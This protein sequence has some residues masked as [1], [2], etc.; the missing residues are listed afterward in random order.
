MYVVVDIGSNTVRMVVFRADG[1]NIKQMLNERVFCGLAGQ[2]EE[3]VLSEDGM[4]ILLDTLR[5]FRISSDRIE[6]TAEFAFA[7]EGIRSINNSDE[8]IRRIKEETGFDV[9]VISGE[10]EA[11]YDYLG[12][13][14][15]L[16][17]K[18][19]ILS[20]VGGG[21]TEVAVYSKE[22]ILYAETMR[23][24]SLGMYKKFVKGIVATPEELELIEQAT[25]DALKDVD[26]IKSFP[27]DSSFC[28]IGGT[29]RAALKVANKLLAKPRG[30][31]KL[32]LEE[33]ESVIDM[34]KNDTVGFCRNVL[35]IKP[36]RLH[37]LL[38]GMCIQHALMK[39]I[40]I[41]EFSVSMSGVREG[42]LK[43]KL[44]ELEGSGQ[45]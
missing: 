17:G 25:T 21:S 20:D 8:V 39:A 44:A 36:E 45:K 33:F 30:N 42:Y 14:S 43:T 19:G 27:I 4:D 41:G 18:I 6:P 22:E 12:A 29:S 11:S 7:T 31:N 24:G 10:E 15:V 9:D 5:N 38:P 13:M 26:K 32:T 40:G 37:T 35:R 34:Y 28:A 23:I 1:G 3:G 2:V 16:D